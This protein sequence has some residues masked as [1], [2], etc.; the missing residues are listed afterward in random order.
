MRA[1]LL[2]IALL[3]AVPARADCAAQ[4]QQ[5]RQRLGQVKPPVA[6]IIPVGYGAE[7]PR[8]GLGSPIKEAGPVVGYSGTTYSLDG[9]VQSREQL[10]ASLRKRRPRF[11]YLAAG[12][13]L[14]ASRLAELSAMAQGAELRLLVMPPQDSQEALQLYE[15]LAKAMG[16]CRPLRNVFADSERAAP[17]KKWEVIRGRAHLALRDCRCE[18]ADPEKL[19]ATLAKLNDPAN[20]AAR[21]QVLKVEPG[22]RDLKLA[23]GASL[24]QV[25]EALWLLPP[26]ERSKPIRL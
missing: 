16:S 6:L 7:A 14:P 9:S 2:S 11:L 20:Q 26:A 13:A 19:A 22:G 8:T 21:Y 18:G 24:G 5:L 15:E 12:A 17:E 10:A 23:P 3:A 4:A 1:L 25:L